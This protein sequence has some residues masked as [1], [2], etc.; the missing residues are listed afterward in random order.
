MSNFVHL[1]L[2][3]QFSLLDGVARI[4]KLVKVL[5]E[6]KAPA[7]AITD[8]GNMYGTVRFFN[9]CKANGIKPILGT[10]FYV[11][12]NYKDKTGKFDYAHLILLAKNATGYKNLCQLNSISWI[13]GF[14]YKPRI[15]Y[16]L[17]SQH[18]EGLICLS[19]C[20]RGDVQRLLSEG[21]EIGRASCRERV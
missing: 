20:L 21:F 10:E 17:L 18:A 16:E 7:C 12:N 3:T 6:R 15:D 14:Y 11:A 9:T 13:D 2:H 1:H 5:K 4:E 8:H 19:G